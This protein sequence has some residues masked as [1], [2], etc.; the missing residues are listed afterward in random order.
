MTKKAAD[1]II[2]SIW[3]LLIAAGLVFSMHTS[4]EGVSRVSGTITSS[5]GNQ[6]DVAAVLRCTGGSWGVIDDAGH[7]PVGVASVETLSDRVRVHYAA[8]LQILTASSDMDETYN[9]YGVTAGSSVGTSYTD[10]FFN[11][12]SGATPRPNL[13]PSTICY[14]Y[15][16]VWFAV[17]AK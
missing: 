17:W 2:L 5:T 15:S 8:P 9:R 3:A 7:A 12:D 13:N 4:S 14:A 16:N 11:H 10:L 1:R 6:P